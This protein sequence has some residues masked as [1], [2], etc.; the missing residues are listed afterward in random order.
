MKEKELEK[1]QLSHQIAGV[2]DELQ[3]DGDEKEN[4]KDVDKGKD[5]KD[6]IYENEWMNW[7]AQKAL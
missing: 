5:D 7:R 1:T 6:E 4:K 2:D 3:K